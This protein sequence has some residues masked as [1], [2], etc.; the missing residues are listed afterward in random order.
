MH[1]DSFD[2]SDFERGKPAWVE[3]IWRLVDGILLNSWLPGSGW[4]VWILR[5]FGARIGTGVVVKPYVKVKFPWRLK[6]GDHSWIGERVWID[7]LA[8]VEIGSHCCLSQG[9]FLCTGN[10]RWDKDSFD[11][12]TLP[13]VLGDHCWIGAMARVA[14]GVTC[15]AG[16]VL[17]MDSFA[18]ADL[19]DWHIH[20]GNPA[21]AVKPRPGPTPG[22]GSGAE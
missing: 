21:R 2:N 9:A 4:R 1:L 8:E 19:E 16:S 12:A 3:A 18:T 14:P 11:L 17:S 6:I 7:N 20:A 15:G 5:R 10:H 13:I 22:R